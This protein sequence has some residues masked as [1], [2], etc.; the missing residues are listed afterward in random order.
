M[1][2]FFFSFAIGAKY[3]LAS[4]ACIRAKVLPYLKCSYHSFQQGKVSVSMNFEWLEIFCQ[5][6][7]TSQIG[8]SYEQKLRDG[9]STL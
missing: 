8:L 2:I 4:D 5:V 6:N 3:A 9:K 7:N 1:Y